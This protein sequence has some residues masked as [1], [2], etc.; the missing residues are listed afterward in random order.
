MD[1]KLAEL[2]TKLHEA[3][4]SFVRVAGRLSPAK[5]QQSGVCGEWSPKEVVAHLVGWDASLKQFV[6]DIEH[7]EPPDNVHKFNAQSVAARQGLSWDEVMHKLQTNFVELGQAI[8]SV[9]PQM[10]IYERV[11]GWMVGRIEDYKLH[12]GQLQSWLGGR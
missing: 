9:E 7:F 4:D 10:R 3:H 8:D 6:I 5:R 1:A 2:W 12:T 11:H